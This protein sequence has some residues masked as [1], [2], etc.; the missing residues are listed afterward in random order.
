[1]SPS[2]R[3]PDISLGIIAIWGLAY[4]SLVLRRTLRVVEYKP[5]MED[6]IW[7]VVLPYIAY[8]VILIAAFILYMNAT[9]A[10]FSVGAMGLLLLFVGIHNAWDT[11]TFLVANNTKSDKANV[12]TVAAGSKAPPAAESASAPPTADPAPRS[13]D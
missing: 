12:H 4:T 1:P 6:W 11:V 9:I 7:H 3:G 10:L 2:L 5:V 8:A 13:S